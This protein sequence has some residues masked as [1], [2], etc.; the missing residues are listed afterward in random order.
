MENLQSLSG[1]TFL[2]VIPL[3]G[4]AL[5]EGPAIIEYGDLEGV[6]GIV[7]NTRHLIHLLF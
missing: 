2:F 6:L 3:T 4:S 5:T 7:Y 1:R